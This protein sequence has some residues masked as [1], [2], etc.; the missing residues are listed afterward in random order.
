MDL[1]SLTL[2]WWFGCK[3][4]PIFANLIKPSDFFSFVDGQKIL[5]VG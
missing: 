1:N 2:G 5:L 4:K 3:L